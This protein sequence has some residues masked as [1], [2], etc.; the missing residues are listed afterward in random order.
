MQPPYSKLL[1]IKQYSQDKAVVNLH[2][3]DHGCFDCSR[4]S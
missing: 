4:T 3:S 1:F 2:V